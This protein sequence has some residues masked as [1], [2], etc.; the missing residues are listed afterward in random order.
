MNEL[1]ALFTAAATMFAAFATFFFVVGDFFK[2]AGGRKYK[3]VAW[4]AAV[5]ALLVVALWV[6][7]EIYQRKPLLFGSVAA[8]LEPESGNAD[9]RNLNDAIAAEVTVSLRVDANRIRPICQ[10]G[11]LH[12][13]NARFGYYVRGFE[14]ETAL[15][16]AGWSVKQ[17]ELAP[18][19]SVP[20][21]TSLSGR[22]SIS[23]TPYAIIRQEED[24]IVSEWRISGGPS[25]SF[26]VVFNPALT[27]LIH[28]EASLFAVLR[29]WLAARFR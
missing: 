26:A 2:K 10:P 14:A 28:R 4:K 3:R 6:K 13:E 9:Q 19:K 29:D 5:L 12:N 20:V 23:G 17:F 11:I 1:A 27:V 24:A 22:R 18:G 15:L 16:P 21:T 25:P 8:Q 7:I